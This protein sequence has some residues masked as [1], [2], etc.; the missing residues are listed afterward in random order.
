MT[1]SILIVLPSIHDVLALEEVLLDRS[2][3]FDLI[4]KP[5]SVSNDCGMVVECSIRNV[6]L[7]RNICRE[8]GIQTLFLYAAGD[9]GVYRRVEQSGSLGSE[10]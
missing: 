5:T 8:L 6:G 2:V 9:D 1:D 4:P 7:I 10:I 3:D